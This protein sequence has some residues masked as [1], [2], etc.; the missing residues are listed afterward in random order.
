MCVLWSLSVSNL[1]I[2]EDSEW[3]MGPR[4]KKCGLRM[5]RNFAFKEMLLFYP[6]NISLAF[7]SCSSLFFTVIEQL[8]YYYCYH[9]ISSFP[10]DKLL[11]CLSIYAY[12][13]FYLSFRLTFYIFIYL[14]AYLSICMYLS[15][16][17]SLSPKSKGQEEDHRNHQMIRRRNWWRGAAA[18]L[19]EESCPASTQAKQNGRWMEK[20]REKKDD[21]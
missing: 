1:L 3:G 6:Q 21:R 4:W 9:L 7:I 14:Y 2:R 17:L 8:H 10:F 15:L 19:G 16:P 11:L 13:S 5:C 12:I 18:P 20:N